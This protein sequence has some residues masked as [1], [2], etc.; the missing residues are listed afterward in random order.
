MLWENSEA[1]LPTPSITDLPSTCH[2]TWGFFRCSTTLRALPISPGAANPIPWMKAVSTALR[3][4]LLAFWRARRVA[5]SSHL[6]RPAT[7][8]SRLIRN[9]WN[10]AFRLNSFGSVL[11]PSSR[12]R[13]IL[14]FPQWSRAPADVV[15]RSWAAITPLAAERARGLLAKSTLLPSERSELR[16]GELIRSYYIFLAKYFKQEVQGPLGSFIRFAAGE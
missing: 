11:I 13:A 15:R 9:A 8:G 3:V 1:Y 14:R 7:K 5:G 12:A 4:R 2:A 6:S 16:L 10:W